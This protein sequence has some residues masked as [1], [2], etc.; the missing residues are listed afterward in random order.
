MLFVYDVEVVGEAGVDGERHVDGVG[1][2][3]GVWVRTCA[4]EVAVA[5]V[6]GPFKALAAS[7][8]EDLRLDE[9]GRDGGAHDGFGLRFGGRLGVDDI[10][11][12]AA[13][14]EA[15]TD[16]E[17]AVGKACPS[18]VGLKEGKVIEGGEG[19]PVVLVVPVVAAE[20]VAYVAFEYGFVPCLEGTRGDL[21]VAASGTVPVGVCLHGEPVGGAVGGG[22]AEPGVAEGGGEADAAV[23][24]EF[25]FFVDERHLDHLRAVGDAGGEGHRD[26]R[27]YGQKG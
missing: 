7:T 8:E 19:A 14:F 3:E 10:W 5:Q 18:E 2:S 24:L 25:A 16:V 26:E 15:E 12:E 21:S 9:C 4:A 13:C 11:E 27:C 17:V 6:E 22:G 20:A 23:D 1:S